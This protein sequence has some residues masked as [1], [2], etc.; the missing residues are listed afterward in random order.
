MM[1]AKVSMWR[2][3]SNLKIISD[4]LKVA[5]RTCYAWMLFSRDHNPHT[6]VTTSEHD[7]ISELRNVTL[8]SNVTLWLPLSSESVYVVTCCLFD[9]LPSFSIGQRLFLKLKKIYPLW[10]CSGLFCTSF[11]MCVGLGILIR[12]DL[13]YFIT[14]LWLSC[15]ISTMSY[16]LFCGVFSVVDMT[17]WTTAWLLWHTE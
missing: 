6:D 10:W 12:I 16:F 9:M 1:R 7:I 2:V 13:C 15:V 11:K 8:R 5:K 3:K 14:S 17:A 4:S